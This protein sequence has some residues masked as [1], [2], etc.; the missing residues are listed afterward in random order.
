M[1]LTNFLSVMM[2]PEIK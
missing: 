2:P 1:I